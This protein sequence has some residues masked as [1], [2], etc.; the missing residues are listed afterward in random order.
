MQRRANLRLHCL[1]IVVSAVGACVGDSIDVEGPA[2]AS[3]YERVPLVATSYGVPD[4]LRI[5]ATASSPDCVVEASNMAGARVQLH[6][7]ALAPVACSLDVRV[8]S[9]DSGALLHSEP[10]SIDF[11][12][13]PR[14]D[15]T[16]GAGCDA[17]AWVELEGATVC[18]RSWCEPELGGHCEPHRETRFVPAGA[19]SVVLEEALILAL[20]GGHALTCGRAGCFVREASG[21][22][23]A[24][25]SAGGP[26]AAWD[27]VSREPVRL[28]RVSGN[29][30]GFRVETFTWAEGA[31]VTEPP[32]DVVVPDWSFTVGTLSA[33]GSHL[34]AWDAALLGS[35][36]T[37][38]L[39]D[40]ASGAEE[41][42]NPIWRGRYLR[43]G[44]AI[45]VPRTTDAAGRSF[46]GRLVTSLED[47]EAGTG[48]TLADTWL[49]GLP[50]IARVA[51]LTQTGGGRSVVRLFDTSVVP[52]RIVAVGQVAGEVLR[53][54]GPDRVLVDPGGPAPGRVLAPVARP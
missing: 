34:L 24:E 25:L 17:D 51:D 14:L 27:V 7:S 43:T 28:R 3:R 2:V 12:D 44:R 21:R 22:A 8:V 11:L 23:V 42:R 19:A 32:V 26:A 37:H 1:S 48:T 30:D 16:G 35:T 5:E 33:W 38:A 15:V 13:V 47:V 36:V 39:F 20:D 54:V 4:A 52:P 53:S 40:L 6:V 46:G 18:G 50:E 41:W 10:W 31:L 49:A 45:L 9:A 29:S